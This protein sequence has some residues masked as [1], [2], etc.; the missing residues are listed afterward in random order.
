MKFI[1]SFALFALLLS[2]SSFYSSKKTVEIVSDLKTE[3]VMVVIIDGPRMTE[4]FG[5]TSCQYIPYLGKIL[6]KEGVLFSNFKN[7]GQTFTN[8]GHTA[9]VTGRYQN[10]TNDG[11]ELPKHPTFFQY[12]L[13]EKKVDKTEAYIVAAK[14][15]LEI[16][17][18]SR[19][20]DWWNKY[21]PS[22]YCGPFGHADSYAGDEATLNK[23]CELIDT[24]PPR[25]TLVNFLAAD[26]YGH[27]N[28]WE[29]YLGAIK[30]IDK[31]VY[32]LWLKIQA[33]EKMKGKT[34]LLITN[35]H[36]RHL[37]GH[38]DGFVNHGDGCDG[39]RNISLLGLGPDF[40]TNI[41][42]KTEGELIDV[43]KTVAHLL[44]F[45]MPTSKGR[46]LIELLK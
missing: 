12:Y 15:K 37:N 39:C 26:S 30:S 46:V 42:V 22:S 36:G 45:N 16:L 18:N 14:G 24:K 23:V 35:D 28:Q 38:K 11:K 9:I 4:T 1:F 27:A 19:H 29:N 6:R 10:V 31:Y 41:E 33:N 17:A 8:S 13:K 25:L 43:S 20:K 2:V 3:Y 34:T 21:M 7:N 44:R 40:K 32:D 5:D